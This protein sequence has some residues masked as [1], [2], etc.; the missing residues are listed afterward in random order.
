MNVLFP[1]YCLFF[2]TSVLMFPPSDI[3]G[4]GSSAIGGQMIRRQS[5]QSALG[6][7]K[8]GSDNVTAGLYF[9]PT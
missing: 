7:E 2:F 4:L 5:S 6:P 8:A 3:D 1:F 9:N